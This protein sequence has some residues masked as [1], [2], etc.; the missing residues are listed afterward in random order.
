MVN[1]QPYNISY[2]YLLWLKVLLILLTV[3][4][5]VNI[6]IGIFNSRL[7]LLL[8]DD[9]YMNWVIATLQLS[10]ASLFIWTNWKMQYDKK[11]KWDNTWKIL[12]LGVIGMW[13][14][15]PS[16]KDIVSL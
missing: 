8:I 5:I 3:I 1:S 16:K 12:L 10:I 13:L 15:M 2:Y 14:W 11:K 6:F 9:Y 7:R 4:H